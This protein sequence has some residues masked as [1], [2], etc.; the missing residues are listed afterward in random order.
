MLFKAIPETQ[1]RMFQRPPQDADLFI[2]VG[3]FRGSLIPF[4]EGDGIVYIESQ[5]LAK[6]LDESLNARRSKNGQRTRVRHLG[7]HHEK[8]RNAETVITVK[9]TDRQDSERLDSELRL[10]E[11][12]LA[13]FPCI[14]EIEL[15]FQSHRQGNESTG[16]HGH[17]AS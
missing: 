14:E 9:V 11:V 3:N 5:N 16:R 6:A 15:S 8:A 7:P 4:A 12:D 1:G 10:F 13:P 17:H 2:P